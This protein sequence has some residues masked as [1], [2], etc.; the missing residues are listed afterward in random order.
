MSFGIYPAEGLWWLYAVFVLGG[1]VMILGYLKMAQESND[2]VKGKWRVLALR[3]I[4]PFSFMG[5]MMGG[6]LVY[7][8]ETATLEITPQALVIHA[9]W[10]SPEILLSDLRLDEA[11]VVNLDQERSLQPVVRTG[12]TGAPTLKAGWFILRNREKAFLLVTKPEKVL[13]LPTRDFVVLASL[14]NPVEFL[15]KL[16]EN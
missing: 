9:G 13:Y 5:L 3:F 10:G 14:K 11:R 6:W 16:N 4:L 2:P 1:F 7:Q 8:Q 12:G 15:E